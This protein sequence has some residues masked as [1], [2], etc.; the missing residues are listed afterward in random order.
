MEVSAEMLVLVV[1]LRRVNERVSGPENVLELATLKRFVVR[2]TVGAHND[3][4]S[5]VIWNCR[6]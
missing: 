1:L 5:H 3:F 6:T 4:G 2:I